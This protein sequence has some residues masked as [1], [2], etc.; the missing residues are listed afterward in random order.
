MEAKA[1]DIERAGA[2]ARLEKLI[3]DVEVFCSPDDGYGSH[4]VV[5]HISNQTSILSDHVG[6]G[7]YL[8]G[9]LSFSWFG[10]Q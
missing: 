9:T 7:I 6:F 3:G 4:C 2:L 1:R 5:S 8:S 10:Q